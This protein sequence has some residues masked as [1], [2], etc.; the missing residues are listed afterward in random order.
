MGASVVKAGIGLGSNEGNRLAHLRRAA[1]ELRLLAVDPGACRFSPVYETQPVDCAPGTAPYLNAV[2]EID[3][4]APPTDLLDG[5][6]RIEQRLGRPSRR[7]RNAPRLIDL[8]LLYFGNLTLSNQEVVIP[9]PRIRSRRFVLAPLNDLA[10]DLVL[11]GCE[12]P[13][14][15]LLAETATSPAVSLLAGDWAR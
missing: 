10:P 4:A 13:V 6:Q 12:Q 5:L 15:V 2:A 1:A 11:P 14:R 3:Y 9:H 7:P 8:D